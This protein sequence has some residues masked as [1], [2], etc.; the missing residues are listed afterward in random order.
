MGDS[1]TQQSAPVTIDPGTLLGIISLIVAVLS[2]LVCVGQVVQQ[3]V[4]T[5]NPIR[6]C[7][8]IVYGGKNGLPGTGTPL[9]Y[10]TL[11][12]IADDSQDAK[13]GSGGS[14]DFAFSTR[15]PKYHSSHYHLQLAYLFLSSSSHHHPLIG[16]H[17]STNS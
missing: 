15:S 11:Q 12:I 5:G 9:E 2:T 17:H 6:L 13:S 8:S 14:S 10:I 4:G 1:N 3:Y 16:L 7:D